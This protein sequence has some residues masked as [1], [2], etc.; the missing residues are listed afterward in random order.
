MIFQPPSQLFDLVIT[1]LSRYQSDFAPQ[2]SIT[3]LV[4]LVS[5]RLSITQP[6][7]MK[8]RVRRT[9]WEKKLPVATSLMTAIAG[10][11]GLKNLP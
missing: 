4:C 1:V 5:Q 7:L 2:Q 9:L 10:A 6:V 11:S 3:S 8:I